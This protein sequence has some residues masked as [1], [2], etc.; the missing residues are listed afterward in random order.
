[1]L[2]LLSKK[3]NGL[4]STT[5]PHPASRPRPCPLRRRIGRHRYATEQARHHVLLTHTR[6][7]YVVCLCES[8]STT[9]ILVW[10][11]SAGRGPQ[12]THDGIILREHPCD[13]VAE[14]LCH[15]VQ[16]RPRPWRHALIYL[17]CPAVARPHHLH[18]QSCARE[19]NLVRNVFLNQCCDGRLVN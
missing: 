6:I 4:G 15:V 11:K 16:I 5:A 14:A 7:L 2:V 9:S 18:T 10:S 3:G 17:G 12:C 8:T 13:L 1:M 19:N